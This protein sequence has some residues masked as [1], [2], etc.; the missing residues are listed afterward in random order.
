VS[1]CNTNHAGIFFWLVDDHMTMYSQFMWK[2]LYSSVQL[3][4]CIDSELKKPM[5][6]IDVRK[7]HSYI[8]QHIHFVQEDVVSMYDEL[9][10]LM[11]NIYGL[12]WQGYTGLVS[13]FEGKFIR[14]SGRIIFVSSE[15]MSAWDL[16]EQII[17]SIVSAVSRKIRRVNEQ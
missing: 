5:Y 9:C 13:P 10:K 2:G 12:P 17:D 6:A 11:P 3:Y 16:L 1:S 14:C 8:A 7:A 4:G 15:K